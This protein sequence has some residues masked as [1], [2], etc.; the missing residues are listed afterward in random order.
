MKYS[1]LLPYS[2]TVNCS[3]TLTSLISDFIPAVIIDFRTNEIGN[4]TIKF[5]VHNRKATPIN[6]LDVSVNS[7]SFIKLNKENLNFS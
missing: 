6:Y 4:D 2:G 1:N 7:G 3:R 5:Q